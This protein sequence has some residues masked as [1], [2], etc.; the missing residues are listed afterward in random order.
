LSSKTINLL[1]QQMNRHLQKTLLTVLAAIIF[2]N[3]EGFAQLNFVV[4][5]L[6][7]DEDS[8][9]YDD[10]NTQVDESM[11][12]VCRDAL[13]RCTIRAAIDEAWNLEQPVNITFSVNGTIN[14]ADELFLTDSSSIIGNHQVTITTQN[15]PSLIALILENDC[16]ILELKF[17]NSVNA[18]KINGDRNIIGLGAPNINSYNEFVN[19]Q[20]GL[21]IEEGNENFIFNNYFGITA[22]GELQP[23]GIS[24]MLVGGNDNKI[25]GTL[26]EEEGNI[27]CGST[28]AGIM[29]MESSRNQVNGNYIGT[30]RDGALGLGNAT[31]IIVSA[32]SNIIG[33]SGSG[34]PE[35]WGNVISGNQVGI[36]LTGAPGLFVA[37]NI[38]QYNTIGLSKNQDV[39]I[40]NNN[41][42]MITNIVFDPWIS[43]NVIA[44]NTGVGIGILGY[45]FLAQVIGPR[46]FRNKIGVN[47]D[48]IIFPNQVG[49]SILGLVKEVV[50]GGVTVISSF[51]NTIVGNSQKGIEIKSFNGL[52]PNKIYFRKNI[53]HSNGLTNVDVDP[54]VNEG[55]NPPFNIWLNGSTI[56]GSHD[57]PNKIIDVYRAKLS[58][59]SPSAY[60]WLGSTITNSNGNFLFHISDPT[61]QAVSVVASDSVAQKTSPFIKYNLVTSVENDIE[62][63]TEFSLEQN[64]PNP[65]NPSTK[66]RFVIPIPNN[67]ERNLKD[68]SSQAPRNDNMQVTLKV[69]DILGKEVA[70]LVNEEKPAGV[71]EVEFDASNLSSGIYFY[72]INIQSDKADTGKFSEIKKMV[73]IK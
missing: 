3:A 36:M 67:R 5:S 11:D 52:S 66:I 39:A 69:Y 45:E 14:L 46:I 16:T 37:D 73:L 4:N 38:I 6:A 55:F 70:T 71:Y 32:D 12:G 61:V 30:N 20:I 24:I 23:N 27:I 9:P 21:I 35:N 51:P 17:E 19:C 28:N 22:S 53:I 68:F 34:Q 18:I 58:E 13:G 7:D 25:G 33:G 41:G 2:F 42:I 59:T 15:D 47:N 48:D 10:P 50:I 56:S 65:F 64:Y 31:G 43:D 63:P 49:I 60:E 72:R 44:G 57:Q 40:P 8:Y 29:I 54:Q 26:F 62:I 1:E